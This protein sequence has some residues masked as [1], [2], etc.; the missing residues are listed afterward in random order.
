MIP[1]T[2]SPRALRE[3]RSAARWIARDNPPAAQAL[4]DAALRAAERI[5]EYPRIG[6][7]RPDFTSSSNHRFVVL[8]GFQYWIVYAADRDPPVIVRVVHASRDLPRLLRNLR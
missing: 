8:T 6:V 5:G 7:V 2:F 1:A 4:L 3:L